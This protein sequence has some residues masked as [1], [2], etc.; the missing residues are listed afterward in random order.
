MEAD[1]HSR[2]MTVCLCECLGTA[3]F[4]FGILGTNLP[5]TIPFS[6]FASVCIWGDITGGHFNPAVTLG[7]FTTLGNYGKNIGFMIMIIASQILGGMLGVGFNWLGSFDRPD[8]SVAVLAPTNPLTG[9]PDNAAN[10]LDFS[11]D[12]QVCINEVMCTFIFI[13]VI[14]MVKGQHTAGDKIGIGAAMFV[15][16]TLLCCIASTNKLGACFNP[17]VGIALTA[18][19][20]WKLGSQHYLYHYLYAYTLGPALGGLLAGLFH[21]IHKEAHKPDEQQYS[22]EHREGLI[23]KDDS[24]Y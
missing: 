22:A 24:N 10:E 4:I 11:M 17:A 14:L 7:V 9:K 19:S 2:M 6:L 5:I 3:L 13:S 1:G 12:L 16:I 8:E 15:C 20:I 21:N 18:N 23:D